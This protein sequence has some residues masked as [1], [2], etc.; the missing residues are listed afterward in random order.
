MLVATN[1]S[2]ITHFLNRRRISWGQ[3]RLHI[4]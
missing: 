3:S 1:I 4:W 2:D